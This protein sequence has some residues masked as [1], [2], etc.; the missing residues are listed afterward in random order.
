MDYHLSSKKYV[1]RTIL[2][3]KN[4]SKGCF[5]TIVLRLEKVVLI[6][7]PPHVVVLYLVTKIIK[8]VSLQKSFANGSFFIEQLYLLLMLLRRMYIL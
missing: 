2:H 4:C 1:K 3:F 5:L 8:V 6:L 7:F